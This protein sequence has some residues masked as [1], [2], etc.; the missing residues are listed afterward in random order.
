MLSGI[1]KPNQRRQEAVCFERGSPDRTIGG[2]SHVE[3]DRQT[4]REEAR[5]MLSGIAEPNH[6]HR[7]IGGKSPC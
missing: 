3:R 7:P 6:N 2:K 4:E 1:A 5:A